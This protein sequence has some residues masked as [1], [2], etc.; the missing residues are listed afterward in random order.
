MAGQTKSELLDRTS[1]AT[2]AVGGAWVKVNAA[3]VAINKV[4]TQLDVEVAG[5]KL[6]G[7]SGGYVAK[8]GVPTLDD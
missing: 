4:L 2:T 3:I 5:G 7:P 6:V 8:Y 1:P